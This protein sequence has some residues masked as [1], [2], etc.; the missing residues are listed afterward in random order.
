VRF[1]LEDHAHAFEQNAAAA[2]ELRL[3]L[4]AI[5]YVPNIEDKY[6]MREL[7][8]RY[9]A[10]VTLFCEDVRRKEKHPR[11]KFWKK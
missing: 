2:D 5:D 6:L 9:Q 4:Y 3:R 7:L 11:W 8:G 1:T 10:N